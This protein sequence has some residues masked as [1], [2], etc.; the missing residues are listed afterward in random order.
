MDRNSRVMSG[1]EQTEGLTAS[2]PEIDTLPQ[3]G[4]L[5]LL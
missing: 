2:P 5:L 4:M 3:V 1:T